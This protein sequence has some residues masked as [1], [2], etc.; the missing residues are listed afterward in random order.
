M[1]WRNQVILVVL[2]GVLALTPPIPE[3]WGDTLRFALPTLGFGCAVLTGNGIEYLGRLALLNAAIYAPKTALADTPINIRPNGETRGFP[4]G[5]SAAAAFGA[6]AIV[7]ECARSSPV[8]AT[9]VILAAG[10]TGASRVDADKH[11]PWQV[12]AG[13]TLGV[14][15]ERGFR[16]RIGAWLRRKRG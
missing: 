1:N 10:F 8:T 13:W 11:N 7:A 15:V 9:A 3:R 4:S 14:L 2:A 6:S 5:H 12:L 16:R